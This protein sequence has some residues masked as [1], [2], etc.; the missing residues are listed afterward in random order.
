MLYISVYQCTT[1]PIIYD[2]KFG[3][4]YYLSIKTIITTRYPC[5]LDDTVEFTVSYGL[6]ESCGHVY[7]CPN[8]FLGVSKQKKKLSKRLL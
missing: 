4:I 5:R 8:G 1:T 3:N 2:K 7:Y 6:V